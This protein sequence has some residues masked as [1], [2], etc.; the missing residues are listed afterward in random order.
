MS[1]KPIKDEHAIERVRFILGFQEELTQKTFDELVASFKKNHSEDYDLNKHIKAKQLGVKI[2]LSNNM[3]QNTEQE[4]ENTIHQFQKTAPSDENNVLERL[5]I[6][7][8]EVSFEVLNYN[9]WAGFYEIIQKLTKQ[10]TDIT[11][12]TAETINI[13]QLT[14]EYWD[15][16]AFEGDTKN[17]DPRLFLKN[18]EHHLPETVFTNGDMWHL[19]K[20]WLQNTGNQNEQIL[21]NLNCIAQDAEHKQTKEI[22]RLVEIHTLTAFRKIYSENSI[23]TL[24]EDM[25]TLHKVS[26]DAFSDNLL[27][28]TKQMVGL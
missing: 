8:G 12:K 21:I 4:P 14:L 16:F 28:G 17:A 19:T 25:Q 2:S 6:E 22:H 23:D 9:R 11:A 15:K 1:W 24:A 10:I 7:R 5:N 18:L 3:V 27:D 26:K 13:H 20:G